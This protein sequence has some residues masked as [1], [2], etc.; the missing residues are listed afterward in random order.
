VSHVAYEASSHGLSQYRNE[1]RAW[2]GAFTNLAAII[3]IITPTWRIISPP[4]CACSRG[5]E[6]AAAR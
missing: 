3:S 6:M 4:R 1:G 5:G 2:S